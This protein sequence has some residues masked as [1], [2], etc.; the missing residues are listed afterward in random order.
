MLDPLLTSLIKHSRKPYM[1]HLAR[2][3]LSDQS[4]APTVAPCTWGHVTCQPCFP[5]SVVGTCMDQPDL[6]TCPHGLQHSDSLAL[7]ALLAAHPPLG[8]YTQAPPAWA[9][10]PLHAGCSLG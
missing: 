6:S 2:I 8:S 9:G 1:G 3:L 7:G 10:A 4:R 5:V